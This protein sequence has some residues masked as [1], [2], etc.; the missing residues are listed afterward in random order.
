M[1]QHSDLE[2]AL[3]TPQEIQSSKATLDEWRNDPARIG[4]LQTLSIRSRNCD[5]D[6]PAYQDIIN[7]LTQ[8]FESGT[9]RL[10]N[11]QTLR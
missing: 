10:Q 1:S 9:S 5:L 4:A 8:L 2:L 11:F 7:S 3:H 6:D